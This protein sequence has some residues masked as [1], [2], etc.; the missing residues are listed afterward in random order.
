MQPLASWAGRQSLGV[1]LD[2]PPRTLPALRFYD[3]MIQMNIVTKL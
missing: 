3:L 2:D 1:G